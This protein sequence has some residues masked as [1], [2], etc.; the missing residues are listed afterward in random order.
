VLRRL[1]LALLA[2]VALLAALPAL[3]HAAYDVRVGV[4]DQSAYMFSNPNYRELG[5]KRTRYF[6]RWDAATD[7]NQLAAADTFVREARAAGVKVLMHISTSDL[8]ERRGKLPTVRQYRSRVGQLV[9][10]YRPQGVTEWG[11]WNEANHDT[12]ETYNNPRRAAQFYTTMRSLC[13]RCTIVALDLLDQRNGPA[14]SRFQSYFRSFMRHVGSRRSTIRV[15]GW[16]NYSEVNR[17][18]TRNTRELIALVR[19]YVPRARIWF[20][21]TGGLAEFG[22]GFPCN[23]SRQA[24]RTTY[25]FRMARDYRRWVKR[26][27]VYNWTGTDCETRFDAGLVNADG[28]PRPAYR[29]FARQLRNFKR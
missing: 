4:G 6:I 12:Q 29:S 20:T 11:V 24:N 21:E 19:R 27:Y 7:V 1:P 22:R 3:G 28:S 5:L 9:R 25:M 15:I 2:A 13:R 16:H 18:Y 10:R 26:L 23:L 14:N 17:R 8:R